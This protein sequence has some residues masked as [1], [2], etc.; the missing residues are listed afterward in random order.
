MPFWSD[1]DVEPKRHN[2]WELHIGGIEPFLV[3]SFSIPSFSLTVSTYKELNNVRSK[4]NIVKWKPCEVE[5]LDLESNSGRKYNTTAKLVSILKNSGYPVIDEPNL[6]NRD[7]IVGDD[8]TSN[9]Y[10]TG[11]D[12]KIS[13]I[14]KEYATNSLGI[15]RFVQVDVDD[16]PIEEWILHKAFLSAFDPDKADYKSDD[17]KKNRFTITYDYATYK[18]L[19]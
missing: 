10:E 15:V 2:R 11:G 6:P 12:N 17:I 19:K 3:G 5:I 16:K 7:E 14:M 8:T 4:P 1:K 18:R 13:N 9:L